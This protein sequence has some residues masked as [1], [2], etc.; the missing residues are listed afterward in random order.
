[1]FDTEEEAAQAYQAKARRFQRIG[2]D[3]V[4]PSDDPIGYIRDEPTAKRARISTSTSSNTLSQPGVSM[5]QGDILSSLQAKLMWERLVAIYQ[6]ILLAKAVAEKMSLSQ[7]TTPNQQRETLLKAL[8][9][10]I[11]MLGVVKE[12]L[13]EAVIRYFIREVSLQQEAGEPAVS[14]HMMFDLPLDPIESAVLPLINLT[15]PL[16]SISSDTSNQP[17]QQQPSDSTTTAADA[18]QRSDTVYD[19]PSLP[20]EAP[21]A[22]SSSVLVPLLSDISVLTNVYSIQQCHS[23]LPESFSHEAKDSAVQSDAEQM[24]KL[25]ELIQLQQS[26]SSTLPPST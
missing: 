9:E 13:E 5:G 26:T 6:R 22:S 25:Q 12:Q 15:T 21:P 24:A 8:G 7:T 20:Q 2:G 10:E 23:L 14:D 4:I 19:V 18:L 17:P 16:D 11:V 1:M 3:D